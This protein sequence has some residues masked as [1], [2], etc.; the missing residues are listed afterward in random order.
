MDDLVK[1]CLLE[2][3]KKNHEE[4]VNISKRVVDLAI[5]QIVSGEQ[6]IQNYE[7]VVEAL[8][9]VTESIS[10]TRYENTSYSEAYA[11]LGKIY[12][13]GVFV[14]KNMKKAYLC[15]KRAAEYSNPFGCYRLACFYE[16]GKYCAKNLSKAGHY[17][18]L[19]ANGGCLRG[20]HKYAM[21]IL[22]GI[23]G[24]KRNVKGAVFYLEQARKLSTP[25]YPHAIHD[26][27]LCHESIPLTIGHVIEDIP[28]AVELYKEGD[29]LGCIRSTLRL[30][31]GYHYGDLNLPPNIQQATEYYTKISEVSAPACFGLYKIFKQSK[32]SAEE[33]KWLKKAAEFG[34]PDAAM[35]YSEMLSTGRGVPMNKLEGKWWHKIAKEKGAK[36]L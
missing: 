32:R 36:H 14:N 26:L 34:H 8:I 29:A 10:G 24:C 27:A 4:V 17:F 3:E 16:Q 21:L 30:A 7:E 1:A 6:I 2:S 31:Q 19:S 13:L 20:V 28:Y 35:I 33:L 23:Y 9:K 18:K 12:E 25:N 5:T 11:L 15:Y 22:E